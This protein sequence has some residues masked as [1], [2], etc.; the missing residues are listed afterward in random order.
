MPPCERC[1]FLNHHALSYCEM[2]DEEE[3]YWKKKRNDVFEIT[4]RQPSPFTTDD[5]GESSEH[6]SSPVPEI[7]E[8]E[9]PAHAPQLDNRNDN[10]PP[11]RVRP[12]LEEE[13]VTLSPMAR[14]RR[15]R[16]RGQRDN[17]QIAAARTIAADVMNGGLR[18]PRNL[19]DDLITDII[20]DAITKPA[21]ADMTLSSKRYTIYM[22]VT[23]SCGY[24]T[25]SGW[26][27]QLQ[28]VKARISNAPAMHRVVSATPSH[29]L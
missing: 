27:T 24:S 25:L 29:L 7:S 5:E 20:L 10:A 26:G 15:I 4:D 22:A 18:R 11:S 3:R 6:I 1:G 17:A 16:R 12:R 9:V 21:L 19:T 28:T 14:R 8:E 23:F 2:C 13:S